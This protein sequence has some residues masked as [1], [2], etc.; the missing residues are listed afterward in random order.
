MVYSSY[1]PGP[2]DLIMASH[3]SDA[4]VTSKSSAKTSSD[5]SRS[6]RQALVAMTGNGGPAAGNSSSTAKGSGSVSRGRSSTPNPKVSAKPVPQVNR[7]MAGGRQSGSSAPLALERTDQQSRSRSPAIPDRGPNTCLWCGSMAS[8]SSEGAE[9]LDQCLE[10]HDFHSKTCIGIPWKVLAQTYHNDK[11]SQIELDKN[12]TAFTETGHLPQD[13]SRNA[14]VGQYDSTGA[15]VYMKYSLMSRV[16]LEAELLEAG[17]HVTDKNIAVATA[18]IPTADLFVP[19][20]AVK[21]KYWIFPRTVKRADLPVL[22]VTAESSSGKNLFLLTT[23]QNAYAGHGSDAYKHLS[24]TESLNISHDTLTPYDVFKA[25]LHGEDVPASKFEAKSRRSSY[26]P[27]RSQPALDTPRKPPAKSVT[28]SASPI[29]NKTSPQ[30]NSSSATPAHQDPLADEDVQHIRIPK[31]VQLADEEQP[32]SDTETANAEGVLRTKRLKCDLWSNA[33]YGSDGNLRWQCER[34]AQTQRNR[35]QIDVA[36]KLDDWAEKYRKVGWLSAHSIMDSTRDERE[37]GLEILEAEY[38]EIPA[39][40]FPRLVTK[41]ATESRDAAKPLQFTEM[42]DCVFPWGLMNLDT[43]FNVS[44]PK[45]SCLLNPI[46]ER[47]TIFKA[48]V[49]NDTLKPFMLEKGGQREA[50]YKLCEE[51]N[52]RCLTIT[53]QRDFKPPESELQAIS[54]LAASAR[55]VMGLQKPSL[56]ADSMF[57]DALTDSKEHSTA[58]GP[59]KTCLSSVAYWATVAPDLKGIFAGAVG[60][61]DAYQ[62]TA[63]RL[64]ASTEELADV[65]FD[66][67]ADYGPDEVAELS[68]AVCR[69]LKAISYSHGAQVGIVAESLSASIPEAITTL[70]NACEALLKRGLHPTAVMPHICSALSEAAVVLPLNAQIS[71]LEIQL[72]TMQ[73]NNDMNSRRHEWLAACASLADQCDEFSLGALDKAIAKFSGAN[74]YDDSQLVNA[75][76]LAV[77]KF[78]E[79]CISAYPKPYPRDDLVGFMTAMQQFISKTPGSDQGC[80]ARMKLAEYL[81]LARSCV[82][83]LAIVDSLKSPDSLSDPAHVAL[84]DA[85]LQA[86]HTMEMLQNKIGSEDLKALSASLTSMVYGPLAATVKDL[87]QHG[88]NN[89]NGIVEVLKK[90]GIKSLVAAATTLSPL[91]GGLGGGKSYRD[92]L[93][94]GK[95]SWIKYK[96]H[97]DSTLGKSEVAAKLE[98]DIKIADEAC[99]NLSGLALVKATGGH[100]IGAMRA[101]VILLALPWAPGHP[102]GF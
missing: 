87:I 65:A 10:H 1:Y 22:K 34:A 68:K 86:K 60:R 85:V 89:T 67:N 54:D 35:K 80:L 70:F 31:T 33:I 6:T 47:M 36:N 81:V 21:Q 39:E 16:H 79:D 69:G 56:F 23:D 2:A 17:V 18:G 4:S 76:E 48:V 64:E 97:I 11:A 52:G 27:K 28:A 95:L 96:S 74:F 63:K 32:P 93:P 9:G 50:A 83:H 30:Q 29:A 72:G 78:L 90:V 42:L 55:L 13:R 41:K 3:K 38:G 49:L 15:E 20:S 37:Q 91:K 62:E 25:G 100:E 84:Q 26:V 14:I 53:N 40:L 94:G 61:L 66:L 57:L 92:D 102:S 43:P 46:E 45:S 82:T 101:L 75:A 99:L 59:G 8:R 98:D 19:G 51:I 12:C 73:R 7:T 88:L 44:D 24:A 77:T 58:Q 71:E 5:R